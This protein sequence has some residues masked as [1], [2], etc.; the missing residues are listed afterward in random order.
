MKYLVNVELA[1]ELEPS[2]PLRRKNFEECDVLIGRVA[3][4]RMSTSQEPRD[5]VDQIDG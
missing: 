3:D 1:S 2:K 5:H 4:I